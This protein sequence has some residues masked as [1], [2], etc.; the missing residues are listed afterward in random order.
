MGRSQWWQLPLNEIISPALV[1]CFSAW[2]TRVKLPINLQC[3]RMRVLRQT[4]ENDPE[5]KYHPQIQDYFA[6]VIT[7]CL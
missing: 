4:G 6:D 3:T 2:G 7:T 5:K 1:H